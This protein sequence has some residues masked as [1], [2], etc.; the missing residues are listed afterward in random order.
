MPDRADPDIEFKPMHKML[1]SIQKGQQGKANNQ[2]RVRTWIVSS[3]CC[4]LRGGG[5]V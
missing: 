3:I 1:P 5:E 2:G 4:I